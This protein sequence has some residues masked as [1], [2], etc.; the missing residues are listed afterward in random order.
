MPAVEI[1]FAVRGPKPLDDLEPFH[2]QPVAV[3][4]LHQRRAEHLHLRAVPAGHHVEREAAAG[5]VIDGGG[6][7]R[8]HQRMDREHV[9]GREHRGIP[10]RGTDAGRP[11]ETLEARA[12]EI[13]DAAEA[14][15]AA[16][17]HQRL[18]L[19]VVGELGERQR[20]RP[21]DL[22]RAVDGRDRAAA[23]EIA[24]EGAELELAIVVERIARLSQLVRSFVVTHLNLHG[25][26]RNP[27]CCTSG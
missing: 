16:D 15:P 26:Y 9:R 13:G 6:L 17:R 19:H 8:H 4:V 25:A 2:G 24:A 22:E 3:V 12:V 18:E 10:G 21:V 20:V 14:L 27:A 11:G 7:L 5:D 23:V 1:E